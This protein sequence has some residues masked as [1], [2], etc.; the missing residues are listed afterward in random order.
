MVS[1]SSVTEAARKSE[2]LQ[3]L[4]VHESRR[5]FTDRLVSEADRSLVEGLLKSVVEGAARKFV[6][7]GLL[8]LPPSKL[9]FCNFVHAESRDYGLV[10]AGRALDRKS[11]V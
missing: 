8:D 7:S 2:L 11:V 1:S 10:E 5:V 9:M 3:K 6:D 4:W